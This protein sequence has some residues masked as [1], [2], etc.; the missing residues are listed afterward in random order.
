MAD[1]SRVKLNSEVVLTAVARQLGMCVVFFKI[2]FKSGESRNS[3]LCLEAIEN[4]SRVLDRLCTV[5]RQGKDWKI[6]NQLRIYPDKFQWS[7]NNALFCTEIH[8]LTFDEITGNTRAQATHWRLSD[9]MYWIHFEYA[10]RFLII[11]LIFYFLRYSLCHLFI[12][13]ISVPL[14]LFSNWFSTKKVSY[15]F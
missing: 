1:S 4:L 11:F 14:Q 13:A 15:A 3:M 7:L 10:R 9:S 12:P 2:I 6:N 5:R 8:Q